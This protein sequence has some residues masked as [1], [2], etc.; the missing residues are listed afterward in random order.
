MLVAECSV[1]G[2]SNMGMARVS[3]AV[4]DKR[5]Y[6]RPCLQK[7]EGT[8]KCA[9]CGKEAFAGDEHFKTVDDKRMCTTCLE[10][11]GLGDAFSVIMEARMAARAQGPQAVTAGVGRADDRAPGGP[12]RGGERAQAG[13]DSGLAALLQENLTR[14]EQV[15]EVII[16]NAGEAVAVTDSRLLILK[17]GMAA[18]SLLARRCT[19]FPYREVRGVDLTVG[20]VYGFLHVLTTEHPEKAQD[21]VGAKKAPN[22][23][24]FLA[25][26]RGQ[27]DALMARLRQEGRCP[28]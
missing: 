15:V 2:A 22:A 12:S 27:F 6:C 18:G 11:A 16:G 28:A 25:N 24:T 14:G 8:V 17:T 3:L 7:T 9:V 21:V 5:W 10:K 19:A 20:A 26:R 4:V 13:L 23:V 1:C